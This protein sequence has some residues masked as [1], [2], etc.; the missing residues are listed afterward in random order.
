MSANIAEKLANFAKAVELHLTAKTLFGEVH[1]HTL[2]AE[3]LESDLA[4]LICVEHTLTPSE[5]NLITALINSKL[6]GETSMVTVAG[7][8]MVKDK[9][10]AMSVR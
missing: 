4:V 2:E 7:L 6:A 3:R 8:T 10:I 1:P 5:L 9:L